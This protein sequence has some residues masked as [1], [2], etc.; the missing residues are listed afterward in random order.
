MI[1]ALM[2]THTLVWL[3]WDMP[4]LPPNAKNALEDR[5]TVVQVSIASFWE[6]GIKAS[7]GKWDLPGD[8]LALQKLIEA[9]GIEIIPI[10]V[11]AIHL[12][13]QMEHHHKDPFDRIIAATALTSGSLLFSNDA[14]FDLYGVA[15]R[16]E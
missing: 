16:W 6:I 8:V 9:Q 1:N 11:T 4:E 7:L 10:T 2:D 13:T 15:R 12:M 5:Q 14:V 3:T